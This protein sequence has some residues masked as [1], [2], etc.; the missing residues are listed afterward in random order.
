MEP[1][2]DGG[3]AFPAPYSENPHGLSIRDY[4]AG[5]ALQGLLVSGKT[6]DVTLLTSFS[7]DLA[8]AMLA[9]RKRS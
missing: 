8:D 1:R 9:E 3:P 4:F 2:D 7:Y 5:M 6:R